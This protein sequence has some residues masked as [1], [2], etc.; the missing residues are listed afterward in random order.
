[1]F[2]IEI[3]NEEYKK[4]NFDFFKDFD[5]I[6][7]P[8]TKRGV[9]RK[10]VCVCVREKERERERERERESACVCMSATNQKILN[11]EKKCF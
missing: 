5:F 8:N 9:K 7:I 6:S 2:S 3:R 4:L 1:M 10:F 11:N